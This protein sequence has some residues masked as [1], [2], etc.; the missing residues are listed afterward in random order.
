MY[1]TPGSHTRRGA[2]DTPWVAP[3][4]QL[5]AVTTRSRLKGPWR[6]PQMMYATLRV[7]RQLREDGQ[8]VRFASVVAGPSE[9]W[10]ITIWRTRHDMQ[11]FMRTG[12]HDDIMWLFSRWL[13][14]FWL[15]RWRPSPREVGQWKGLHLAQP[16]PSDARPALEGARAEALRNALDH[17]PRLKAATA[18]DGSVGYDSTPYARRRRA[19]VGGAGGVVIHVRT[20]PWRTFEAVVTLRRLRQWAEA[21]Q[22]MLRGVVGIGKPGEIY[23]LALWATR[24]GADRLLDSPEFAALGRRFPKLWANEWMPENEFGHWDG[25]RLRQARERYGIAVP[26]IAMD[27]ARPSD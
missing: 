3:P 16:E 27:V 22:D 12:A 13:K 18:A 25:V 19:E 9:F 6:F 24:E 2:W 17:L 14:S 5:F 4:E 1:S 10:T 26:K 8:V 11:E 20:S 21:D 15:M 23:L 7:R